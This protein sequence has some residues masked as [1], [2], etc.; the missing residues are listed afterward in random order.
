[1]KRY[2]LSN[3]ILRGGSWSV[4]DVVQNA[5][6]FSH[7]IKS[8]AIRYRDKLNKQEAAIPGGYNKRLKS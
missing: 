4:I 8:V 3:P 1:M 6:V 7:G 5:V 2:I